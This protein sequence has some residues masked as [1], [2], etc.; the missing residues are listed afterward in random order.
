MSST[1]SALV[2]HA[3]PSVL[4]RIAR[5]LG[6]AGLKIATRVSPEDSLDYIARSRPD[7]VL[8][9]I[10]FWQDGWGA[11]IL[12]ASPETVVMPVLDAPESPARQDVA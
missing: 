12:A 11:E 4:T 8:L 5:T 9:G 7:V 10:E 2:I 3:E 6:H 1:L